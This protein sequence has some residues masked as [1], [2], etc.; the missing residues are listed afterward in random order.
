M[1]EDKSNG[2]YEPI[3]NNAS[4]EAW[5]TDKMQCYRVLIERWHAASTNNWP[6]MITVITVISMIDWAILTRP[7]N[8][9]RFGRLTPLL[10]AFRLSRCQQTLIHWSR[11]KFLFKS[12]LP[13]PQWLTRSCRQQLLLLP[14]VLARITTIR[15]S[16][17]AINVTALIV[18]LTNYR[19]RSPANCCYCCCCCCSI[20]ELMLSSIEISIKI[21]QLC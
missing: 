15:P 4:F 3:V 21:K 10:D 11:P 14:L 13:H 2:Q 16:I 18:T 5:Q 7:I 6:T 17:V 8:N 20:L 9:A 19:K 12:S 1:A